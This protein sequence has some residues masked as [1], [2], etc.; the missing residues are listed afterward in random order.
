MDRY[1]EQTPYRTYKKDCYENS[2]EYT[3]EKHFIAV[4]WRTIPAWHC[5]ECKR[6]YDR[7]HLVR[8]EVCIDMTPHG[9]NLYRVYSAKSGYCPECVRKHAVD[10]GLKSLRNLLSVSH[11]YGTVYRNKERQVCYAGGLVMPEGYEW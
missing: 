10:D 3:D 9:N 5:I 2:P 11:K 6:E 1:L 4:D 8:A 7:N